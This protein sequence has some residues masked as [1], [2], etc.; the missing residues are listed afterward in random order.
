MVHSQVLKPRWEVTMATTP[1]VERTLATPPAREVG[2]SL[3]GNSLV[4][5]KTLNPEHEGVL[6]Q[7][8]DGLG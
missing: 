4:S 3:K 5:S 1:H 2:Q 7:Y 6:M 8:G